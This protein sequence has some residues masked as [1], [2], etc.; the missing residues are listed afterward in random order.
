[1]NYTLKNLPER[2]TKPR[3]IG[4]TMAM[5][6]GLS[7]R[8]AEDF[9]STCADHVD[10]VKLGWATSYV[11]PHLKEKI[12]VYTDAGI[13][14]YFGGTLFEAFIIR[15]QFDDYRKLLD[16]YNL[17]FAEVSDGSIDLD[18]DKKCDYIRKLTPR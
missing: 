15:D 17:Q 7:V 5:D 1:M 6:K 3:Q 10:I 16:K 12:K 8:Q 2:T 14:C 4:Y 13:P 11:T 18:H 9:V